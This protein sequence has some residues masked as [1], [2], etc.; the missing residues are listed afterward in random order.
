VADANELQ[1]QADA[2]RA[3]VSKEEDLEQRF[4]KL[5]EK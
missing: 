3:P 2:A 4:A 1:F 5:Q